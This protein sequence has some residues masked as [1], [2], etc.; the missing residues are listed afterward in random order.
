MS[1][2]YQ[3]LLQFIFSYTHLNFKVLI[4]YFSLFFEFL[5]FLTFGL[6]GFQRG[7]SP[8]ASVM[9]PSNKNWAIA[10]F[11]SDMQHSLLHATHTHQTTQN[12]CIC[13]IDP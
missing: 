10:I 12:R 2:S 8:L 1:H 9:L 13:V 4:L 3:L 7:Y 6:G 11:L 5:C